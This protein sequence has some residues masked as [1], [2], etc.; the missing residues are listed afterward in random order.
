MDAE[1]H[2]RGKNA[3]EGILVTGTREWTDYLV[4]VSQFVINIGAA[5]R[6]SRE[7]SWSQPVLCPGLC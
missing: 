2:L 7:G 4:V 5:C 3:G 6:R 1:V